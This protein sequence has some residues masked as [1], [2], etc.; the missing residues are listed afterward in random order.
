MCAMFDDSRLPRADE[1][2]LTPAEAA[3]KLKVTAEQVRA[4]IRTGQLAAINV[5]TGQ[6]RPLYRITPQA[7]ADF[8][9][10]RHQHGLAIKP[11][12]F[13]RLPPVPDLFPHL[14]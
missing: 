12:R 2:L 3:A 1:E 11:N 8:L 5:G 7:L 10:R 6:K 13:K 4:L 14:R 9:G